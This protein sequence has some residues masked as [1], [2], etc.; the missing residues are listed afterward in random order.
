MSKIKPLI[1]TAVAAS[2]MAGTVLFVM[3]GLESLNQIQTSQASNPNEQLTSAPNADRTVATA[4]AVTNDVFT[5]VPD[6]YYQPAQQAGR[7]ETLTYDS[8]DYTREEQPLQ[9]EATVYL[10]AGYDA[11]KSYN[12]LY[13]MHGGGGDETT[14]L[15]SPQAPNRLKNIL[16]HMIADGV[17]EPLIIVAPAIT[18]ESVMEGTTNTFYKELENDLM[19]KAERTYATYAKGV[20]AKDFQDSRQ[21]R[22]FGGFSMGAVTTWSVLQNSLDYFQYFLPMSGDSWSQGF[23]GG[24]DHPT[25]TAQALNASINSYDEAYRNYKIFSATGTADSGY[26]SLNGQ[27]SALLND[28]TFKLTQGN[29]DQGNVIY[30]TVEGNLH[31]YPYTY[32]YIYNALPLFFN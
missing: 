32:Q 3:Q 1:L 2:L 31:D 5:S 19:P 22:A 10:P 8:K 30:Y 27:Y 4:Q 23:M 7:L 21:H 25:E 29:F 6:S 12:I 26:Q 9:K 14:Y 13:L 28:S 15:G 16:D 17:I 11:S 18:N 20:T 24:R